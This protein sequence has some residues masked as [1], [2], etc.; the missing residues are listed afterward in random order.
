ME[1][2]Y[3]IEIFH[4]QID[5][6][7]FEFSIKV[8]GKNIQV[9]LEKNCIYFDA[10]EED[11][12]GSLKLLHSKLKFPVY[13]LSKEPEDLSCQVFNQIS[14]HFGVKIE[15]SLSESG[16][17]GLTW[18]DFDI[19]SESIK[20]IKPKI[21]KEI[22]VSYIAEVPAD[23]WSTL[24]KAEG[25]TDQQISDIREKQLQFKRESN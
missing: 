18:I 7:S 14:K 6:M 15:G 2:S 13:N 19:D 10:D 23:Y 11:L 20:R 9:K 5:I 25:M 21:G 4:I 22:D 3:V 12:G 24:W 17:Q 16:R 8:I 1:K